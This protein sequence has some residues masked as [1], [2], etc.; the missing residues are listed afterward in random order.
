M[1]ENI[2]YLFTIFALGI[3]LKKR[4]EKNIDALIDF[5]VY[6]SLPALVFSHI[7]RL[8][9]DSS[10]VLIILFGW[11]VIIFSIMLSATVGKFLKLP[12]KSLLTFIMVSSFGNTA[13]LGYPYIQTLI[14]DEGLGY[15]VIFDNLASFLPVVTLGTFIISFENKTSKLDIKKILTSPA[16]LALIAAL[17]AK[18]VNISET[19]LSICDSLGSTITPLALFAVGV[20]IDFSKLKSIKYPILFSLFIKMI[21][22]PLLAIFVWQLF[23]EI[24]IKAKAALLEIAMPPMVLASIMVMKAKLD[25]DLAVASVGLGVVLS[26]V[27]VP[28]IYWILD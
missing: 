24:D 18:S 20:K 23:F 16:F 11:A 14:G 28:M 26:F 9:I 13:F 1:I 12:K 5:I 21:L 7:Y 6:V 19:I 4:F 10:I 27:T 17:L 15:A 25:S 3:I 22:V 2:L 8:S